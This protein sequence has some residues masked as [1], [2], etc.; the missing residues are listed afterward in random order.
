MDII[1]QIFGPA[2]EMDRLAEVNRHDEREWIRQLVRL[3]DERGLTQTDVGK[4][5]GIGQST[6]ARIESGEKD[7]RLSTLLRYALAV[8]ARVQ[9][10]VSPVEDDV[11]LVPENL[12]QPSDFITWSIAQDDTPEVAATD[13]ENMAVATSTGD[14]E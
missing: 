5:M 7:V 8:Q 1:D 2:T 3:R 13:D 14:S 6:V 10:H 9:H 12:P 4:L 11:V